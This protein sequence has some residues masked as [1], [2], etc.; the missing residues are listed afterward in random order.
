MAGYYSV[1]RF[2]RTTFAILLAT[3]C[4]AQLALGQYTFVQD[5]D[6]VGDWSDLLNWD[7]DNDSGTPNLSYPNGIGVT[8]QINQ[9]IKSGVGAYTL[10]M[11]TTDVTVGQLI[12]DN[13]NDDYATRITMANHAPGRLIF[14]DSSGTAKWIETSN[15]ADAPQNVQN[16]IQVLIQLNSDLEITQGNYPNLNSGTIFTNRFDGDASRKIIKKGLG[17]IQ[18]NLNTALTTGQGFFGQILIQE[19]AIRTINKTHFLSTVSGITVSPGG[20]LQLADNAA[21]AVPDYNLGAGAVLNISGV[22]TSA[23]SSGPEGALRFGITFQGTPLNRTMTFHNPVVLQGDSV[24]S[25]GGVSNTGVLEKPVTGPYS[26]TKHG[27][28]KL[29]IMDPLSGWGGDTHI[30]T[31]PTSAPISGNSVLSL[32][33]PILA[34]GKD[35]YMSPTRTGLVLDFT[36]TDTIR[37]FFIDSVE[38]LTGTWGAIGSVALGANHESALITGTGWLNVVGATL[39]GDYNGNGI[40]DAADYVL[41]R[42]DPNAHGG[43]PGGYNTWRANFGAPGSGSGALGAGAAPEPAALTL[44]MCGLLSFAATQRALRTRG[45]DDCGTAEFGDLATTNSLGM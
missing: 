38:Q 22:G 40:V 16:S 17:G 18:L 25:A 45:P 23:P 13:T 35:L 29:V 12:I 15:T 30:L 43:D 24:I 33:N 21:T 26:L 7:T 44:I 39:A 28:G 8:A 11:P 4:S 27:D 3:A 36:G 9:P 14:E 37:S 20:Q 31:A 19:G 34:D 41:W 42:K 1:W 32:K 5:T 6:S 2:S 10:D